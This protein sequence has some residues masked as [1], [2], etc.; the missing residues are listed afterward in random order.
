LLVVALYGLANQ[1]LGV[2]GAYVQV[3]TFLRGGPQVEMWRVW[4]FL[5]LVVGAGLVALLRGGPAVGLGYGALG[6]L[7]PVAA[8]VP[9]LFVAGVAMGYGA[10]SQ[11]AAAFLK[12]IGYERVANLAGGTNG[13]RASGL[14]VETGM[15]GATA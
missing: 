10:R 15:V 2:S 14:A 9:L 5:G 7:L 11:R 1:R 12:A 3:A 6:L 8:L 4:F 13:W